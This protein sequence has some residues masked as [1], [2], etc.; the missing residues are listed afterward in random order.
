MRWALRLS[1]YEPPAAYAFLMARVVDK[2]PDGAVL[3]EVPP[4]DA[5]DLE[6]GTDVEVRR[7]GSEGGGDWPEPFGALAGRMPSVEIE[8]IKAARREALRS[9]IRF[10]RDDRLA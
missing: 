6:I 7:V 8:D 3:I 2:R 4:E 10:R 1:E 9:P 5:A